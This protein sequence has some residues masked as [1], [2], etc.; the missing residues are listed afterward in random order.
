L[1]KSPRH[2]R[3]IDLKTAPGIGLGPCDSQVTS[4]ITVLTPPTVSMTA[5]ASGATYVTPA[6][7]NLAA[8]ATAGQGRSSR[9]ISTPVGRA[10][11]H[12]S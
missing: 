9:S 4:N 7:V 5:P 2:R 8:S 1:H 6:T 11:D 10:S 3:D 12:G